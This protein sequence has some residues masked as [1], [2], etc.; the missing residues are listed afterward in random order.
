M[1]LCLLLVAGMRHFELADGEAVFL[2]EQ[3]VGGG[4][5][6]RGLVQT[7]FDVLLPR[8]KTEAAAGQSLAACF[9]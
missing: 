5:R 7:L 1:P 9:S 2:R 4:E 6:L 3:F 8:G